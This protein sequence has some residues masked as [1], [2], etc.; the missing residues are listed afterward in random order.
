MGRARE[1]ALVPLEPEEA[2]ALWTEVR[3]WPSF[4]EGFA[5]VLELDAE[6][7]S[8][9]STV[10]WESVPGGRGRVTERVLAHEPGREFETQVFDEELAG[11]QAVSFRPGDD[12]GTAVE[13]ELRYELARGGPLRA[14]TDFLFIRRALTDSLRRTLRRY[15]VEALEQSAL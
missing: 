1:I 8:T 13:V 14:V 11:T 15:S 4:V 5:R 7:P 2:M 6:W 10:V 3:R 12:E 9:G